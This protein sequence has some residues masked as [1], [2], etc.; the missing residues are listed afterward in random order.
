MQETLPVLLGAFAGLALTVLFWRRES[1]ARHIA[2][3]GFAGGL[4]T[5]FTG[6]FTVSWGYLLIDIPLGIIG[7]LATRVLLVRCFRP[8]P[9]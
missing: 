1:S 4:A 7:A 5:V 9:S 3:S 8:H 2:I 6:E